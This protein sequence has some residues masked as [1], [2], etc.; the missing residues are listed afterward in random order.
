MTLAEQAELALRLVREA[1]VIAYD[2]ETSGLD[3]RKHSVV[4]YVVTAGRDANVY[5]PVRHGGGGNLGDPQCGPLVNP[6]DQTVQHGFEKSLAEAFRERQR[7]S[8][9]TVGH[10]I[11]FDAHMGAN[12]GILLGRDLEDTQINEALLDEFSRSFSLDGCARVHGVTAKQGQVMY[13]HLA[14]TLGGLADKAQM[15]NYWRLSGVDPIAVDYATGDGITTLELRA[16]QIVKLREQNL[17]RVHEVESRL[18]WTIFRIERRGIKINVGRVEEIRERVG[19]RIREAEA[20]LPS[21]FNVRSSKQVREYIESAGHSEWPVTEKGNPSFTEKWLKTHKEGKLILDVRKLTNLM[22]MFVTPLI[23]EHLHKGRVH[24][25]LNQMKADE[26][27]TISGRFSSSSPNLQQVPRRNKD[28]GHLFRSIFI[29]DEGMDFYEGDYSQCEPRL[30]AHYSKDEA[31]LTG[32]NQNPPRDVHQIVADLM[33]VERD[34]TAKMMNMGIFNGMQARSLSGHMGWTVEKAADMLKTWDSLFPGVVEFRQKAREVFR[35]R[36][37]VRTLLGRVC[38][39]DD[40][41]FAYRA[42]SRIIQGGNADI[43]K[44]KLLQADKA[45]E[46]DGDRLHLLMTVH[47][48]FEWQAPTGN[49]CDM[50]KILFEDVQNEPFNLRVPFVMEIGKGANWA[51]ATYGA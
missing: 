48:S 45:L 43:L 42:V 30:F 15:G 51:E 22:N 39:L 24:A 49:K 50:L 19:Q 46:A 17:E 20:R 1:P 4:G 32:Y 16:A 10:N 25:G 11:K 2:T 38:R 31:L 34:P 13:D 14:R 28:L 37:N 47:D 18:I 23:E 44:Y 29:P 5:I 35:T 12:H 41:R 21:G 9:L 7:R 40:P 3:W 6:D 26:Y 36:G 33:G 27:G 8:F